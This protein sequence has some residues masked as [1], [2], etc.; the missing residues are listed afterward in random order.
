MSLR[1]P[2][3]VSAPAL[4][5]IGFMVL[6]GFTNTV[7]V[8]AVK[9][10]SSDLHPAQISFFRCLIGL[11]ML[12]PV[13]WHAGGAAVVRTSHPWLHVLRG[14]LNAVGMLSFFWAVSLAPLAT[15][16][17]IN[18]TAPLFA[19]LL[20]I[21]ILGER[22]GARRWSALVVGFA[23]T[24]LILRPGGELLG[25]GALLALGASVV[26]AGAMIVIKRLTETESSLSITVWAAFF[27]G[28]FTLVPALLVWK[29]PT[30][31]QW[32][33]L[34][35]IGALGSVVQLSLS[36]AFALAD[37]SV[38]LPFDFL[39][40]VWASL[41]GIVFFAEVP[42]LFTW[43]GGSMIFVS[44]VYVAYRERRPRTT[45]EGYG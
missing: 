33:W 37:T 9:V 30:P 42:D 25:D 35:G 5:G 11:I 34:V 41:F 12:L 16:S 31:I 7:M 1:L 2:Q 14:A 10:L 6:S 15:V 20:A 26:W 27:V 39:K 23:S 21:L 13:I 18:F 36:R 17:A 28:L 24:L 40:L 8:S 45:P 44:S 4:L 3:G 19:T 32:G 38:V 43:V 22:V 29:W